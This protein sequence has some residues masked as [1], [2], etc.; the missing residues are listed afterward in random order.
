MSDTGKGASGK[1]E[2]SQAYSYYVVF[3]LLLAYIFSFLD[4]MVLNLM[5]DLIRKDL[6]LSEVEVSYLAGA[7][8]A[9]CYIIFALPFGWYADRFGRRTLIAVGIAFWS[10][11]TVACGLAN[12]FWTLFVARMGVGV[13][14]ASINPAAYSM[15][16]DYFPPEKRGLAMSI[17]ALGPAIG[18][19]LAVLIGGLVIEWA[20][21]T[22]PILPLLGQIAPWKI[23]FIVVGLPGLLVALLV[24]LTVREP[25]RRTN[26]KDD[27]AH[28][29]S[30]REVASYMR[31]HGWMFFLVFSGY[32]AVVI[33]GYAF[34][35]WGPSY[36]MRLH[37]LS[38]AEVGY[39]YSVAFV[40]FGVPGMLLGGLWCD[41]MQARGK[42]EGAV[43]VTLGCAILQ[44]PLFIAAY[45]A[46]DTMVAQAC[47]VIGLFVHCFFGGMQGTMVQAL[48]PARMRGQIGAVYL[49]TANLIGLGVAPTVT[50]W[51]TENIFGGTMGVG[52]SLALTTAVALVAAVVFLAPSLKLVRARASALHG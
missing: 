47:F 11:A 13:G 5:L 17:F 16:P 7:A 24:L 23:A 32:T 44:G 36:F 34:N 25:R 8:F 26:S 9:L 29:P 33:T 15:I 39:L 4:R 31:T 35:F 19:G 42:P 6:N 46:S 30:P 37:G 51:M 10:I 3:V 20:V 1:W 38:H 50:A 21:R 27:T 14:E 52:R 18:G 43:R 41:R 48:S 28:A 40:V 2:Y 49:L 45:L 22:Q 12:K